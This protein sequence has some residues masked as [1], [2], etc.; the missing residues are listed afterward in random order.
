MLHF[1]LGENASEVGVGMHWRARGRVVIA[2]QG[3]IRA[4]TV[5]DRPGIIIALLQDAPEAALNYRHNGS[6]LLRGSMFKLGIP[7]FEE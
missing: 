6:F 4:C 7:D 3:R 2:M 5:D 1:K